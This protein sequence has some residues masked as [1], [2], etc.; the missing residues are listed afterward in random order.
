MPDV[1]AKP[2]KGAE[3]SARSIID[4]IF[5]TVEQAMIGTTDSIPIAFI[6]FAERPPAI[7]PMPWGDSATKHI[8]V[9]AI[10]EVMRRT[11]AI[12]Y[13]ITSEA[14]MA[15]YNQGEHPGVDGK[16]PMP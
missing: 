12:G 15:T 8:M 1:K 9:R 11:G 7:V 6:Y 16:T 3:V 13:G 10:G 5:E 2:L 14:W 4:S